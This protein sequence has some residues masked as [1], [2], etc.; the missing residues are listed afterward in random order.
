MNTSENKTDIEVLHD[1]LMHF[2]SKQSAAISSV[3]EDIRR[4]DT[5]LASALA[6]KCDKEDCDEN[7]ADIK[8]LGVAVTHAR[9][10]LA[11]IA[12]L[13]SGAMLA[14]KALVFG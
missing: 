11:G 8:D 10:K 14:L 12:G 3:R 13:A 1:W 4:M 7:A 6:L 9:T 5:K 2:D